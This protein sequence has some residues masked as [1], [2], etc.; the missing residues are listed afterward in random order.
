MNSIGIRLYKITLQAGARR[1]EADLTNDGFDTY[2]IVNRFL[3]DRI[4]ANDR[5]DRLRTWYVERREVGG[6]YIR[7]F[8]KYGHYGYESDLID[9]E[10]NENQYRR[11]STDIEVI[12]L[13]Y[14]FWI[15]DHGKLG[16]AAFQSFQ[17]KSCIDIVASD[18]MNYFSNVHHESRLL[19]RKTMPSSGDAALLGQQVKRLVWTKKNQ[20]ADTADELRNLPITEF[21]VEMSFKAKRRGRF[22]TLRD[23]LHELQDVRERSTFVYQGVEFEQG[24]AEVLIGN[25]LQK[26]GVFG[27]HTNAGVIDITDQVELVDGHPSYESIVPVVDGL[28][29]DMFGELTR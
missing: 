24:C 14:S 12:P 5:N 4:T 22:G 10:T 6:R 7:G 27:F 9:R 18:L 19:L 16:I 26:V 29:E 1:E 20:S 23:V 13:Y 11:K 2:G 3:R 15:P 8:F 21:D 28:T 25:K 17:G